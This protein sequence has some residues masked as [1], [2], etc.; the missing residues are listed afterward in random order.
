MKQNF[1]KAIGKEVPKLLKNKKEASI[2]ARFY[3]IASEMDYDEEI[4]TVKLLENL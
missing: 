4:D 1:I 3:K 2:V